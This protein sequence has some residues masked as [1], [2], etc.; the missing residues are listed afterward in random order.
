[1]FNFHGVLAA[2]ASLVAGGSGQSAS[3]PIYLT[4]EPVGESVRIQVVGSS[5]ADYEA[6]FSLEVDGGGNQS[7]HRGSATLRAGDV[8]TLSTVT[9]GLRPAADW[10]ARLRVEPRDGQGYEQVRT[11][12]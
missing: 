9:I 1:M 4:A 2:M 6:T 5:D 12:R 8:V 3:A 7:R 10:R 11:S